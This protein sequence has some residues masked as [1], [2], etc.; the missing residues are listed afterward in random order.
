MSNYVGIPNIDRRHN[1][2]HGPLNSAQFA[3]NCSCGRGRCII[4]DRRKSLLLM[5][6]SHFCSYQQKLNDKCQILNFINILHFIEST[7]YD[8][9]LEQCE[10]K[11]SKYK[12][13]YDNLFR[14][15]LRKSNK[16]N[17][18]FCY[19]YIKNNY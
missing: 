1:F 2:R 5:L 19:T 10:W 6:T 12:I 16:K 18:Y 8:N 4:W 11:T 3:T 15:V 14:H 9:I 13:K 7:L 17:S